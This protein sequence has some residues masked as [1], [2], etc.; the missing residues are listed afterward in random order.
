MPLNLL[1]L[2]AVSLPWAAGYLFVAVADHGL[3]PVTATVA[4]MVVPVATP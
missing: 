4:A 3:P 1:L 2:L